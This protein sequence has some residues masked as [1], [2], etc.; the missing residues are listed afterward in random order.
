MRIK[1]FWTADHTYFRL[2]NIFFF[3]NMTLI[4]WNA[5]RSFQIKK[6]ILGP[7]GGFCVSIGAKKTES[8]ILTPSLG[9]VLAGIKLYTV[10]TQPL[11]VFQLSIWLNVV[12][13]F[14]GTS[15]QIYYLIATKRANLKWTRK[16]K[17]G[18]RSL[19]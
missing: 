16:S 19:F 7:Y 1:M 13:Y 17:I 15:W 8:P 3:Q 12:S 2:N 6:Y 11:S 14:D 4:L 9:I 10:Y 18:A 5:C